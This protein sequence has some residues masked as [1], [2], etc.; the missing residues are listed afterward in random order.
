MNS[1]TKIGIVAIVCCVIGAALFL[2]DAP[3]TS[4]EH[5]QGAMIKV[6][7]VFAVLWLAYPQITKLPVWLS[8]AIVLVAITTAVASSVWKKAALVAIPI[9]I[10]LWMLRP[11]PAPS[12][13]PKKK[14]VSRSSSEAR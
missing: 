8:L 12:S 11:R 9:L 10:V 7:G 3:T 6:G 2:V 1:R 5:F 4:L 13:P 14:E